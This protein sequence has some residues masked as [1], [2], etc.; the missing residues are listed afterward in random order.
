M[1]DEQKNAE[2]AALRRELAGYEARGLADRAALVRARI[3]DLTGEPA[4]PAAS[5]KRGRVSSTRLRS[6]GAETR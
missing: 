3:A 4:A 5:A 6:S 1:T 2:V